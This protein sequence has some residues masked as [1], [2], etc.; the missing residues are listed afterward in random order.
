[1]RVLKS[2]DRMGT[3][4]EINLILDLRGFLSK[5]NNEASL[6]GEIAGKFT[7]YLEEGNLFDLMAITGYDPSDGEVGPTATSDLVYSALEYMQPK[8][9]LS[10]E[11]LYK[12]AEMF[13]VSLRAHIIAVTNCT[14][15]QPKVLSHKEHLFITIYR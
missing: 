1:M 11:L 13:V 15:F 8:A 7:D 5:F 6:Y 4:P 12:S 9:T 3:T 10:E 14:I 2:F